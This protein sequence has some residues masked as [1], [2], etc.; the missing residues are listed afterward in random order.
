MA[1][2]LLTNTETDIS[3]YLHGKKLI[4]EAITN[5]GIETA[6]TDSYETIV[7]NINSISPL[8]IKLKKIALT[9]AEWYN[10]YFIS[11]STSGQPNPWFINGN[12]IQANSSNWGAI[13]GVPDNTIIIQ[14]VFKFADSTAE[15]DDATLRTA[16]MC[17]PNTEDDFFKYESFFTGTYQYSTYSETSSVLSIYI[18]TKDGTQTKRNIQSIASPPEKIQIG[19]WNKTLQIQAITFYTS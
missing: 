4:A 6:D 16:S 11:T 12:Y 5:K 9:G 7:K 19:P 13:L 3:P 1:D 14:Y 8:N 2:S 17:M 18:T 10:N 15:L